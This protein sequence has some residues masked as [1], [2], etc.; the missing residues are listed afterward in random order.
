V[1]SEFDIFAHKPVQHAIQETNVVAYKPIIPIDQKYLKFLISA[2]YDMYVDPE[3]KLY[4]RGKFAKADGS[5]LDATDYT[6][7]VNNFLHSLFSQCTIPLNGVNIKQ[8]G[9]LYNCRAY[10]KTLKSCY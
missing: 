4:I 1:S 5:A 8:S 6:A 3:I 2:D 7:G 9:D 10:L